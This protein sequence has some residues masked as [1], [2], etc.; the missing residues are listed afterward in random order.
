[1]Q[2]VKLGDNKHVVAS[3]W[4]LAIR[5]D[6]WNNWNINTLSLP[7]RSHHDLSSE[8]GGLKSSGNRE[9]TEEKARFRVWNSRGYITINMSSLDKSGAK[10]PNHNLEKWRSQASLGH[11]L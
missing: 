4:K 9:A 10:V 5:I 1:V 11:Y 6:L 8:A 3:K 7:I 2:E